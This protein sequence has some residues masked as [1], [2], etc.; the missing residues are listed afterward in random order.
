MTSFRLS[1]DD[2]EVFETKK[3]YQKEIL[4]LS[5][6]VVAYF[7]R[8][9]NIFAWLI[10]ENADS[11]QVADFG[12]VLQSGLDRAA[13][14]ERWAYNN[15]Q[16]DY[17]PSDDDCFQVLKM[18]N[19]DTKLTKDIINAYKTVCLETNIFDVLSAFYDDFNDILEQQ[20]KFKNLL[21][22]M[23]LAKYAA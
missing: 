1:D 2:I 21:R 6:T 13:I 22:G 5:A 3:E 7:R 12:R 15:E 20:S 10:E 19:E 9:S 16:L 17:L 4:A 8:I 18:L 14:L 23:R 11:P